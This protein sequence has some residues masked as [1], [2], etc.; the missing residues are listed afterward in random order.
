MWCIKYR[1]NLWQYLRSQKFPKYFTQIFPL[2]LCLNICTSICCAKNTAK[3]YGII[4]GRK[5]F[6]N[7]LRLFF[8]KIFALCKKFHGFLHTFLRK[9]TQCKKCHKNLQKKLRKKREKCQSPYSVYKMKFFP[10]RVWKN[11]ALVRS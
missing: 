8:A 7:L 6:W 4:Y 1:K 2:I 5:N 10:S 11:S 3:F 9:N